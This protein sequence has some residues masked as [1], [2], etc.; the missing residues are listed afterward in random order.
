MPAMRKLAR[1][2]SFSYDGVEITETSWLMC[3][4]AFEGLL[5]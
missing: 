1:M 4:L 5:W 3:L 2:I